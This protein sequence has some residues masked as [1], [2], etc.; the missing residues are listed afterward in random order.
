MKDI[1]EN[2]NKI[3]PGAQAVEARIKREG[4]REGSQG[5]RR[6][7][8]K[9]EKGGGG[10]GLGLKRRG[11]SL[12]EKTGTSA[13]K[14]SQERTWPP[15]PPPPPPEPVLGFPAVGCTP[16]PFPVPFE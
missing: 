5:A 4:G 3:R 12:Q 6:T 2:K 11:R 7:V 13:E 9:E 10:V 16:P 14:K 1:L 15:M 8:K